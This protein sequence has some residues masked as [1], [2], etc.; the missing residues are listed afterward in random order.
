MDPSQAL[1]LLDAINAGLN[2]YYRYANDK[3]KRTTATELLLAPVTRSITISADATQTT[4]SPFL[5]SERGKSVVIAGDS[6]FNEIVATNQILRPYQGAG[7]TVA[8]TI[9]S[10][11]VAIRNFYVERLA[12]HPPI[13]DNSHDCG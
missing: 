8:A 10:D 2:R 12:T 1:E 3:Y 9:Y 6:Q 13:V 11:A 5:L 7:G 4:G